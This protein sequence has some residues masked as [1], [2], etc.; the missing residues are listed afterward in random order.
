MKA[1]IVRNEGVLS[2]TQWDA[3]HSLDEEIIKR[4]RSFIELAAERLG[5][6][7]EIKDDR[8]YLSNEQKP[9]LRILNGGMGLL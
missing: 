1:D 9:V 2:G 5:Y 4:I 7:H 6:T 3:D 8:L